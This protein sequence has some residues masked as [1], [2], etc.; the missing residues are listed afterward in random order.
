[1]QLNSQCFTSPKTSICLSLFKM[2]LNIKLGMKVFQTISLNFNYDSEVNVFDLLL[3]SQDIL[4]QN[5]L[6]FRVTRTRSR[7][8]GVRC[9][10]G[11]QPASNP[12]AATILTTRLWL[13]MGKSNPYSH[14]VLPKAFRSEIPLAIVHPRKQCE[15]LISIQWALSSV[16]MR[17]LSGRCFQIHFV[18]LLICRDSISFHD[19]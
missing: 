4:I 8:A 2:F 11:P 19:C 6:I 13:R 18:C 9:L 10:R 1:M 17:L 12:P 5:I 15:G 7:K 14:C 16:Q 3:K